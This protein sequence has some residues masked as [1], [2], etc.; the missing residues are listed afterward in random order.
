MKIMSLGVGEA[1]RPIKST[2]AEKK[3]KKIN[4]S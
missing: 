3:V 2:Q 1:A 4:F